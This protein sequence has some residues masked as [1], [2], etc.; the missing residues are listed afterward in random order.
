MSANDFVLNF[1]ELFQGWD[2]FVN[3]YYQNVTEN[4]LASVCEA[5]LAIAWVSGGWEGIEPFYDV[6][7]CYIKKDFKTT[8]Q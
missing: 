4:E 8:L 5:L 6:C 3:R 7:R 2:I 1:S